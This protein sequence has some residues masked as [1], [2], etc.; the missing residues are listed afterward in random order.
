VAQAEAESYAT[1]LATAYRT[2]TGVTPE[3]MICQAASGA[4]V[5]V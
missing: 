3:T 2:R 5:V 4:Q 1:R